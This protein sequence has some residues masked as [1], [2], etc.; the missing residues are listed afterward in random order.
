[1]LWSDLSMSLL[2]LLDSLYNPSSVVTY[3]SY[4]L[5]FYE[6]DKSSFSESKD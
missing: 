1:M 2:K 6:E 5:L 4:S 3:C